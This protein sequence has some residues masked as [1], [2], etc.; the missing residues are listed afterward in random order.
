MILSFRHGFL[1]VRARK[2][3]GTSAEIA[4]ST[5]CGGRDIVPPMIA[6]DE[7]AR[8]MIGGFSGN[9]SKHPRFETAYAR[10]VMLADEGD[11]ARLEPPPSIYTP[12][13]SV[14]AVANA[15]AIALEQ[16]RIVAIVRDPYSRIISALHMS[17]HFDAY[18]RG[19]PMP[20]ETIDLAGAL[21]AARAR[22]ELGYLATAP[23]YGER[24]DYLLRYETLAADLAVLADLLK[25]TLP[26]LPHAKRGARADTMDPGAVFR[27][28]Q[29]D[30]I[31]TVFA[32]DFD[33]YGYPMA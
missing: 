18:R 17:R 30:W 13:M 9:Y 4:L 22:D 12:H 5:I 8:Q 23:I 27:R 1:F 6:I 14:A 20:Q 31:N 15:A 21:D 3:A 33:A 25:V 2:V 28:D 11:L 26:P 32:S 19:L 16:F 29:L 7:R 24:I 10:A